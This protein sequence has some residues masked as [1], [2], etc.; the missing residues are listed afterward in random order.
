MDKGPHYEVKDLS[1]AGQGKM[2]IELA[3]SH[4]AALLVVKRRFEKEARLGAE[5]RR[6]GAEQLRRDRRLAPRS[7][8][9]P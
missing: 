7:R 8:R 3:E 5:L 4:M 2:N 9:S 6:A 1:L